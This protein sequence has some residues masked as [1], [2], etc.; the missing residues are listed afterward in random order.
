MK[1]LKQSSWGLNIVKRRV[2]LNNKMPLHR[3]IVTGFADN[4]ELINY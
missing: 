4:I 3:K 1:E 2:K